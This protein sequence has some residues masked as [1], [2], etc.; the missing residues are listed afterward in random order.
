MTT[1][2]FLIVLSV[3]IFVHEL[4]HFLIARLFKVRVDEFAIGFPPRLFSFKKG[5][6]TYA[7]N[8]IP[9]GG[10]VKIYGENPGDALSPDNILAKP[11]WQQALVLIAGVTFNALFA[12]AL[13]AS[14][15]MIGAKAETGSF[16]VQYS[17]R[18]SVLITGVSKAGPAELAGLKAGDEILAL[19]SGVS[20]STSATTKSQKSNPNVD[21]RNIVVPE[22]VDTYMASTS[23]II[24]T[25]DV[26]E[27]IVQ[28]TS[29]LGFVINR[30]GVLLTIVTVPKD[31]IDGI[32]SGKKGVGIMMG[33]VA[34]VKLPLGSAIVAGFHQTVDIIKEIAVSTFDFLV[35]IFKGQAKASE[36]SGPVGIAS[37]V[38][39][40]A[41]LGWVY[42]ANF[43]AF[44]SLNLAVLN[45]LP[46][47]A[48][49]GGRLVV[50]IIEAIRRKSLNQKVLQIA[51]T[52]SFFL[53]IALMLFVTFQDVFA[54][55]KK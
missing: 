34:T 45:L 26:R 4:G 20:T 3:L 41:R 24:K 18:P 33:D 11:R 55:F 14:T 50:V 31:G 7:I 46:I 36:V 40:A 54:L 10:Y 52:V 43:A 42:L 30:G 16:P 35:R 37:H 22:T 17:G 8:L 51:N 9:L 47:P 15:L 39:E 25:A 13:F 53:L 38:G 44:I 5:G 21:T 29:T 19:Q 23:P 48:L 6:T 2:I 27:A 32:A 1:I 49:D 28:S 12:W